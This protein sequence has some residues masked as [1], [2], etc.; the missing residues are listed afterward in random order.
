MRN[1][2]LLF[3][4][5][6][7]MLLINLSCKDDDDDSCINFSTAFV[8]AVDAPETGTVSEVTPIE[9]DFEVF[10]GCTVFENFIETQED[11]VIT[12]EIETKSEGCIC[13]LPVLTL[14]TTYR[15]IPENPGDYKLNFKSGPTEF[16]TVDI[17]VN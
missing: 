17:T 4:L 6:I 11:N 3:Y 14:S 9:V 5:S 2:T 1:K 13:T 12:V 16:I 8:T 15:F 10:N 7:L